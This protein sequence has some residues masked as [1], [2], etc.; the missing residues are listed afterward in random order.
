VELC[1]PAGATSPGAPRRERVFPEDPKDYFGLTDGVGL[2]AFV[3]VAS[4]RPLPAY[5][6]WK[7]QV[8]GGLAWA[9]LD[10]EGF[11]SYDSAASS[12]AARFRGRLRGDILR[13]ESAPEGLVNLCDRLRQS[14][15]VTLVRAVAFPVK[16][17]K[18]IL[19]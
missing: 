8:P 11:W 5:E 9:R 3:V 14:P 12:E 13:R 10:R 2:Q 6:S 4:D 16:L 7:A 15:G 19:K 17:G 1:G 18:E